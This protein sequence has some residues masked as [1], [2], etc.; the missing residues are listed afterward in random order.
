MTE[1]WFP[2]AEKTVH[3]IIPEAADLP[4]DVKN[5]VIPEPDTLPGE[6]D[7][8]DPEITERD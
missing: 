7:P 4:D 6:P 3:E 1:R 8:T 5:G 2:E